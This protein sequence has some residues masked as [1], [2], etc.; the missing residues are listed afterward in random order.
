VVPACSTHAACFVDVA[1]PCGALL[2]APDCGAT[3]ACSSVTAHRSSASGVDADPL[4]LVSLGGL[5]VL[6]LPGAVDGF[7]CTHANDAAQCA[8][9]GEAY[10][11]MGGDT[12]TNNDGWRSAAAGVPTDYCTFHGVSCEVAP[13]PVLFTACAPY[14]AN[15]TNSAR[16]NSTPTCSVA[17]P[18]GHKYTITTCPIIT[19]GTDLMLNGNTYLRVLDSIGPQIA[20]TAYT[21][22]YWL[23]V[24][25]GGSCGHASTVVLDAPWALSVDFHNVTIKQGCLGDSYCNATVRIRIHTAP[26]AVQHM[27]VLACACAGA[28]VCLSAHRRLTCVL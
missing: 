7:A 20:F 16:T 11:L 9:L 3:P 23:L 18:A 21:S 13:D 25:D 4:Q 15:A 8:A 26:V 2:N 10:T 27:C 1:S 5:S 17:L 24:D 28:H 22:L 12:W 14:E 6:A 19:M